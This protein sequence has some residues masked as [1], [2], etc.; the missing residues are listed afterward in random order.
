MGP[1]A[2]TTAGLGA[3]RASAI[4]LTLRDGRLYQ[5]GGWPTLALWLLSIAARV[6]VA[7]PFEHTA[8]GLA[9]TVTLTLSFGVSLA[10]QY[11][12]FEARVRP[13]MDRRQ[14]AA[15]STLGR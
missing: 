1:D 7:L 6:L 9:L 12:V 2:C 15:G 8:V 11:L 4:R 5:R 10:A 13:R 14:A 3:V